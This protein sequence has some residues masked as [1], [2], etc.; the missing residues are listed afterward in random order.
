MEC[1]VLATTQHSELN[2]VNATKPEKLETAPTVSP[3]RNSTSSSF[4][5]I[6]KT[7]ATY[8][9]YEHDDGQHGGGMVAE[10]LR[11][12]TSFT[13]GGILPLGHMLRRKRRSAYEPEEDEVVTDKLTP[14][15]AAF[16]VEEVTQYNQ[17]LDEIFAS[18]NARS[19]DYKA[20]TVLEPC[21]QDDSGITKAVEARGGRGIRRG[22][23]KG[24]D[25]NK[26]SCSTRGR[27]PHDCFLSCQE[28]LAGSQDSGRGPLRSGR[29]GLCS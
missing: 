8:D 7:S 12:S 24:R 15:E 13:P 19:P 29:A 4:M 18:L 20:P 22:L 1:G 26:K 10:E 11:R 23:F 5:A 28:L 21:C 17:D 9:V 27:Q 16:L 6:G 14:E 25:L 2:M 3:A